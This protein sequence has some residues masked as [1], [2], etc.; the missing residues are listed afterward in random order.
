M[1]AASA[2]RLLQGE[3][4]EPGRIVLPPGTWQERASAW[5]G[6]RWPRLAG[7]AAGLAII[8]TIAVPLRAWMQRVDRATAKSA[9][10]ELFHLK[11]PNIKH[12]VHP[13]YG[14]LDYGEHL[15]LVPKNAEGKTLYLLSIGGDNVVKVLDETEM[16]RDEEGAWRWDPGPPPVETMILLAC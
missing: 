4:A 9:Q 1:L 3:A 6:D 5:L 8:L 11:G 13:Q 12:E 15:L 10:L 7:A 2:R 14:P 16:T